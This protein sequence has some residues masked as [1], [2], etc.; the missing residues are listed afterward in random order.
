MLSV[1]TTAKQKLKEAL[2]SKTSDPEVAIRI[3]PSTSAPNR[4]GLAIDKEKEGDQV[5]NDDE[6]KR[7]LLIGSNLVPMLEGMVFDYQETP[8]GS[9]F[10]ISNVH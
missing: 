3:I 6:G 9:G 1:T 10:T 5:V 2:Q 8:Q 4:L 7:V